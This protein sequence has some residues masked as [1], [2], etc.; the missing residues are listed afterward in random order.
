MIIGL[1]KSIKQWVNVFL[2]LAVQMLQVNYSAEA[3]RKV[4]A[5]TFDLR[6]SS[7]Y[8]AAAANVRI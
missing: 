2:H 3:I 8:D 5:I 1:G 4:N 7:I 6:R